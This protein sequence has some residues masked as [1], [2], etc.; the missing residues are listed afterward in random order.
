LNPPASPQRFFP[1]R[2]VSE[3][4]PV[5]ISVLLTQPDGQ[6]RLLFA[7]RRW[8]EMV[9]TELEALQADPD[10]A[11]EAVHPTDR[12]S[13]QQLSAARVAAG[14]SLHWQGRLLVAGKVSWVR[15]DSM[16]I[17]QADGCLLWEA[18]MT[19]ISDLKQR[20][21][22]LQQRQQELHRILD[23]LPIPLG[24][25]RTDGDQSIVF[26][27]RCF[28]ETF[29]YDLG[30]V[31]NVASWMQQAYPLPL[32]RRFYEVRWQRDVVS[33]R[34]GDG[35]IPARDY[36]VTCRDGSRRDVWLSGVVL[37]DLLV[38]AFLDITQRRRAELEL[39][40][41]RRRE[42]G[43]R[44]QQLAEL[45]RKLQSS[46]TA[47]AMVH[48]IQQP[49]STLLIGAQ[50][51][52]S[53][54]EQASQPGFQQL[55]SLL[56]TQRDQAQ[57]LQQTTEKMRALLRNVQTPHRPVNLSEVLE[58]ALLFLRRT[59]LDAGIAV[60]IQATNAPCWVA[61]D[62]AQLQIAVANLLR[63]AMEALLSAATVEPRVAVTLRR[64]GG[65]LELEVAD[66]GP[67]LPPGLLDDNPVVDSSE[68]KGMGVGLYV[69]QTT[70]ENHGGT[71]CLGRSP[72][73]GATAI[74]RLPALPNPPAGP[75]SL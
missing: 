16:P 31:P 3:Q 45:E 42:R 40:L 26:F 5:G 13:F 68:T 69:V 8:L 71:L 43:Q 74:L 72:Q 65:A 48:E 49:L 1:W 59:L 11:F 17:P 56:V 70:M 55:R 58:S 28:S 4:I 24:S 50:L 27:N 73:G 34:R 62:G 36:R 38:A 53:S 46:L 20:E 7:S 67:G 14:E 10:L 12:E 39:A 22:E 29:G 57:L 15:I 2:G 25:S 30:T 32:R 23:N 66:N 61:G 60:E 19:D 37:D 44:Q 6:P 64:D 21:L 9:N 47:A 75:S 35:R 41:A 51:A 33:A 54:L 63:N 52:L 18:V